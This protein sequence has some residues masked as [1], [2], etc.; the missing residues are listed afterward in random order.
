MLTIS[1]I[2]PP[3]RPPP[4]IQP[5]LLQALYITWIFIIKSSIRLWFKLCV[6]SIQCAFGQLLG[7]RILRDSTR[8]FY[9]HCS[10][11]EI[12]LVRTSFI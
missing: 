1:L 7:E 5:I 11:D 4:G 12:S 8:Y 9:S 10:D 6:L 2:L 3:P